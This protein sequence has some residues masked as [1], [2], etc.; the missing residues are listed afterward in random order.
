MNDHVLKDAYH[1]WFTG[2]LSDFAG[3]LILPLFLAYVFNTRSQSVIVAT[4][5]FFVYWKSPL[6]QGLIEGINATGLLHYG[7]VVD[8]TDL[9]ALVVL[10]LSWRILRVP[11]RFAF[12]LR[13]AA[14]LAR[15]AVFPLAVLALIATSEDDEFFPT[16]GIESCCFN[17]FTLDTFN[18][19][20]I[21]IPSAF[22]PDGDGINDR[23]RVI[24]DTGI[25]RVDTLRVRQIDDGQT[26][27]TAVNV[28]PAGAATIGWDGSVGGEIESQQVEYD[29]WVT[30]LDGQQRRYTGFAC[31]LPCRTPTGLPRP[32]GL[33]GCRFPNQVDIAGFFDAEVPSGEALDCFE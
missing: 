19:G 16:S 8:Y 28:S 32:E 13:P 10:P 26:V 7:R 9:L 20:R 1:N 17:G 25:V 30:N 18:A 5:L 4:A 29:V 27:F 12:R 33:D 24:V 2:K 23:F 15:Y 11:E 31:S 6:S 21:Y 22:T 14:A 3:V